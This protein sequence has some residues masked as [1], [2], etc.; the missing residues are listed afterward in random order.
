MEKRLNSIWGK[1]AES[2]SDELY[3]HILRELYHNA[4][5]N[6]M[7]HPRYSP[8]SDGKFSPWE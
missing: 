5:V 4:R 6:Q 3:Q 7:G 1:R 2:D 8:E